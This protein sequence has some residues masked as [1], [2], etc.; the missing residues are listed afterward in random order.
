M[1]KGFVIALCLVSCGGSDTRPAQ[2]P[3]DTVVVVPQAS[4][5][6]SEPEAAPPG[7]GKSSGA[8][9]WRDRPKGSPE[10]EQRAQLAFESAKRLMNQGQHAEAC[11]MFEQSLGFSPALGSL[12]NLAVCLEL[13]GRK[14]EACTH[15]L[16]A[17]EWAKEERRNERAELARSKAAALGCTR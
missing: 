4:A 2:Q 1:S 5:E 7:R 15:Y 6:S 14:D 10:D 16:E 3:G 17:F 12:L 8:V 13:S 11:K 9:R